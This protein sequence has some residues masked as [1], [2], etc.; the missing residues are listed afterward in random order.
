LRKLAWAG[1]VSVVLLAA[2]VGWF[3]LR[4]TL[5]AVSSG[6]P[7]IPATLLINAVQLALAGFAWG[8]LLP[9]RLPAWH[10]VR[11]RWVREAVNSVLPVASLGGSVVGARL[12][13]R[14]RGVDTATAGASAAVDI[15]GEAVAQMAFLVLALLLASTLPHAPFRALWVAAPLAVMV[16]CLIAA[17]AAGLIGWIERFCLRVLPP[18]LAAGVRGLEQRLRALYAAPRRLAV[19]ILYNFLSWS[20]GA[21]EVWVLLRA[22]G[23]GVPWRA[24]YPIEALGLVARS[25]GFALP[26]GVGAQETGFVLAGALFGIPHEASLAMSLLKR[27]RELIV[28]VAGVVYWQWIEWQALA[29]EAKPDRL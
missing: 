29:P 3:G 2:L 1:S 28:G 20:V 26:A 18:R 24:A 7:S 22:L 19:N 15:T 17:Q 14:D 23:H 25:L 9:V 13:A 6:L 21:A 4:G 10:L 27:V 5:G 11:A 12:L 8:A 16:A